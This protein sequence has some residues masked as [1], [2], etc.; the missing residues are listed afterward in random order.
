M[1]P[2]G[3]VALRV[4]ALFAGGGDGVEADVG[5]EDDGAAGEDAG[6]AVGR[7][8]RVVRWVDEAQADEDERRMAASLMSTMMLLVRADSRMPRT[9]MTVSRMTTRKAGMLKP[10]CQPGL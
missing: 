7:E 4:V 2:M 10:K 6:P 5:E 9:R 1:M 3:T 8:G